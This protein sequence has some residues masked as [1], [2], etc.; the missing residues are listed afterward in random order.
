MGFVLPFCLALSKREC[1]VTIYYNP[2]STHQML[3]VLCNYN[4]FGKLFLPT[5]MLGKSSNCARE[6][7]LHKVNFLVERN[8]ELDLRLQDLQALR[9]TATS[10]QPRTRTSASLGSRTIHPVLHTCQSSS[11]TG[12]FHPPDH[13][14]DAVQPR[15]A[16]IHAPTMALS[17]CECQVCWHNWPL[18]SITSDQAHSPKQNKRTLTS[19]TLPQ[20]P[21]QPAGHECWP[22]GPVH[23][24][25]TVLPATTLGLSPQAQE[26]PTSDLELEPHSSYVWDQNLQA[27][28]V[29]LKLVSSSFFLHT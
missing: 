26:A 23:M 6:T 1:K 28:R 14:T 22:Q 24:G 5:H 20:T 12:S 13:N 17:E 16:L 4:T 9:S 11:G 29:V 8:C 25:C 3:H 15:Q 7:F 27:P 19:T 2:F 10:T 21:G 18:P